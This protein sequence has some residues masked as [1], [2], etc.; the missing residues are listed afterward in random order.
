M[1]EKKS[2]ARKSGGSTVGKEVLVGL[3]C[4]VLGG[5]NLLNEFG[6]LSYE[7]TVPNI[8]ANALLAIAGL[9][10]LLQAYKIARHHFFSHH[11]LE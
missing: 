5:S 9:L 2:K 7:I 6:M 3:V 11:F 4:L 10:L 1:S 8:I